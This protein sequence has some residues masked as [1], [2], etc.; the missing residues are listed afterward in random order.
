MLASDLKGTEGHHEDVQRIF[1]QAV[2]I[3]VVDDEVLIC[4]LLVRRL[5]AAGYACRCCSSGAEAMEELRG[6]EYDLLLADILMPGMEGTTLLREAL[7]LSPD[8]AVILVTGV[9]DI[10]TAVDAIKL[11]AYDYITKPFRLDQVVVSVNR[12]LE[13]RRLRMENRR[14]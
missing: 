10:G 2:R 7:R 4:D 6:S 9:A 14:Y 8:L 13:R 1:P 5:S 12:A 11:C 3:L